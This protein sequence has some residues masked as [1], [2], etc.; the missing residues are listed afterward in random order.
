MT[1]TIAEA[2]VK[3]ELTNKRLISDR[4]WTRLTNR[5]VKEENVDLALAERIMDQALGFLR[6]CAETTGKSFSPSPLVDIG[7]HAFILYTREYAEFCDRVAGRFIH[8]TPFDEEGADCALG[9]IAQTVAALRQHGI[10]VHEALWGETSAR[11][12]EK[13]GCNSGGDCAGSS[14]CSSCGGGGGC[15]G[16]GG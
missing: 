1:M 6:L 8:H 14:S 4:L 12:N 3:T 9:G 15:G 11:C 2:P 10:A 7:W 5:I 13:K 16:C